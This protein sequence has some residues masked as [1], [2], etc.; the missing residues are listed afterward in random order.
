MPAVLVSSS[1]IGLVQ[2]TQRF[3]QLALVQIPA[4]TAQYVLPLLCCMY[5]PNLAGIVAL[6]LAVRFIATIA[7]MLNASR[8]IPGLFANFTFGGRG[9]G[10]LF[11]FGSWITI[12]NIVSPFQVYMDRFFVAGVVGASA[13]AYY[14]VPQDAAMRVVILPASVVSAVFPAMSAAMG[15][16]FGRMNY[17]ASESLRA[18]LACMCM[19]ILAVASLSHEVM[20]MWMGPMFA[21]Q[22]ADVLSIILIGVLMNSVTRVPQAALNAAGR[23]DVLAKLQAIELPFQIVITWGSLHLFGL[24]GAASAWSL[25]HI[26]EMVALFYCSRR[27]AGVSYGTQNDTRFRFGLI[28]VSIAA[29]ALAFV[30]RTQ[31][32]FDIRIAAELVIFGSGC[33]CSWFFLM[34]VEGRRTIGMRVLHLASGLRV[35]VSQFT[36]SL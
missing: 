11:Q 26:F 7:N 28:L 16:D 31:H 35:K 15:T 27:V 12:S 20:R 2:A 4:S 5:S 33:I 32:V 6:L 21:A 9:L 17:L 25:R 1:V 36:G 30:S 23:P 22:S 19:P 29:L 10:S 8:L 34:S 3:D 24:R 18:I 14:S 13:V